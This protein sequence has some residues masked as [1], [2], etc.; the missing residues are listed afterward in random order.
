MS[1]TSTLTRAD[2]ESMSEDELIEHVL[3][4]QQQQTDLELR[5][6]A[7]Q[8]QFS[9]FKEVLAGDADEFATW[10][11]NEMEPFIDRVRTLEDEV[12]DH[13]EKFEMFV[14]ED[15]Q[16][17]TPDKRAMHLRQVIYNNAQTNGGKARLD[18]DQCESALGGGLHNHTMLDAMKRAADGAEAEIQGSCNLQPIPG[19]TVSIASTPAEQTVI[20]LDSV[21]L[22]R[23]ALRQ[24][25]LTESGDKRRSA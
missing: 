11:T 22:S 17:A 19:L 4:L 21:E 15:G 20:V 6:T 25:L 18:R 23:S 16:A 12:G 14:V 2:L 9:R 10:D 7:L 13:T 5:M 1:S 8:K 3:D 24:N